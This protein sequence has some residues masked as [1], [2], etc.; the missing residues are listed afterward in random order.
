MPIPLVKV[1][2]KALAIT[3]VSQWT[4]DWIGVWALI[5]GA[6]AVS[7]AAFVYIA[8]GDPAAASG[9]LLAIALIIGVVARERAQNDH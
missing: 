1:P 9:V 8:D 7:L 4:I 6:I 5:L 3:R 2:D